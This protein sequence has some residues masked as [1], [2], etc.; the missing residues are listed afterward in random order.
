MFKL[1]TDPRVHWPVRV[2]VPV[3]GGGHRVDTFTVEFRIIGRDRLNELHAQDTTRE[4]MLREVVVG[5]SELVNDK[6]EPL[7]F[8]SST[9]GLILDV[10]YVA[11]ALL[12]AYAEALSGGARKN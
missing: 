12:E 10:P 4:A 5:W 3:D 7:P 2:R 11:S 6:G 9:L 8:L 1:T